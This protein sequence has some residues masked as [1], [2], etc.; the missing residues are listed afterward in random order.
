MMVVAMAFA[1][2]GTS[3]IHSA[4]PT[5]CAP[6][7]STLSRA[8]LPTQEMAKTVLSAALRDRHPQWI[9]IPMGST[10]IRSFVVF[11]E[12]MDHAPALVI[13]AKGQGM[14]D[15]LRAVGDDAAQQGFIAVVPDLLPGTPPDAVIQYAM[16]MPASNGNGASV[17]FNFESVKPRIETV[18]DSP[19]RQ[20][21]SFELTDH[22]WH[23]ALAFLGQI[24]TFTVAAPQ[25]PASGT[26][27]KSDDRPNMGSKPAALP[28]NF[29]MTAKT[30]AQSPRK[31]GWTDIPMTSGTKLRTWISY[32]ETKGKAP[33]VL[34]FQPG[35]GMDMGE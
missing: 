2:A 18:I 19:T 22:S 33:V 13:T 9:D 16:N 8:G 12:R 7:S 30:V 27:P 4:M 29:L 32:P 20:S 26:R 5:Y 10:R 23:T 6:D 31:G 28:A 3:S 11:P 25:V 24:N 1:F 34:V 15:W 21:R 14:T 35:P 17:T